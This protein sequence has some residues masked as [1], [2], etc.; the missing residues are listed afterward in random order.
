MAQ[1]EAAQ[2]E[3]E[4]DFEMVEAPND[5]GGH[6]FISAD[7]VAFSASSTPHGESRGGHEQGGVEGKEDGDDGDDDSNDDNDDEVGLQQLSSPALLALLLLL[8][9][10]LKHLSAL[11]QGSQFCEVWRQVRYSRSTEEAGKQSE[12]LCCVFFSFYASENGQNVARKTQRVCFDSR[13]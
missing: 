11:R 10:F 12:G 13:F 6:S 9:S 7:D 8:K 1:K 5:G 3:E 2:E 4:D